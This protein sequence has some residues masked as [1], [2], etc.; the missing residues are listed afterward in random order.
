LLFIY[1]P[2]SEILVTGA[3]QEKNRGYKKPWIFTPISIRQDSL[4][5]DKNA[6]EAIA[7]AA[8]ACLLM[9]V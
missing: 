2:I 5:T 1:T 8:S 6:K 7:S 9:G 3:C 4:R